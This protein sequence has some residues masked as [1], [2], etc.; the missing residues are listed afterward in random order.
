VALHIV[1]QGELVT[2][3]DLEVIVIFRPAIEHR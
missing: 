1:A 3:T 2:L